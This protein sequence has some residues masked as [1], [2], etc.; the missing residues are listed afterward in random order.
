[1]ATRLS[2]K[3]KNMVQH[4]KFSLS[5]MFAAVFAAC[6]AQA[7][8]PEAAKQMIADAAREGDAKIGR[9]HV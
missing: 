6:P 4:D 8:L 2:L 7:E 5:V 1:M 9:A 3:A